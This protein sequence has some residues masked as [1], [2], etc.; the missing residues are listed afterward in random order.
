[1]RLLRLAG[2]LFTLIGRSFGNLGAILNAGGNLIR[3]PGGFVVDVGVEAVK[4]PE[5][6][7][8]TSV[9]YQRFQSQAM[10]ASFP[11]RVHRRVAAE[12]PLITPAP[13]AAVQPRQDSPETICSSDDSA[14]SS[15]YRALVTVDVC[16][17]I[18]SAWQSVD[19]TDEEAAL[20]L[21]IDWPSMDDPQWV[22][23]AFDDPFASCSVYAGTV[24]PTIAAELASNAG[25]CSSVYATMMA[26]EATSDF[27]T[28]TVQAEPT[29][30]IPTFAGTETGSALQSTMNGRLMAPIFI[31][32]ALLGM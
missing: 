21:C 5:D 1:M 22:G 30:T 31:V 14:C 16:T 7:A 9:N 10:K 3:K 13:T 29:G 20:C 27:G 12:R 15:C 18:F 6:L 17:S 25:F 8:P 23:D 32:A 11:T 4:N 19:L 2:I 28:A 24:E 26:V